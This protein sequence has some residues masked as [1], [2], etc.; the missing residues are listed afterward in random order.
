MTPFR[1]SWPSGDGVTK[2]RL[3][4]DGYRTETVVVPLDRGIDLSFALHKVAQAEPHKHRETKH[5]PAGP[6]PAAKA[7][8]APAAAPAPAPKPP[9][10]SEPVPL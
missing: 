6:A 7:P 9:S 10:R 2:L 3:E 1:E 4:L 5:S 8:A